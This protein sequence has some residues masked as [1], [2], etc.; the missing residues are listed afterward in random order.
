[1]SPETN[2]EDIDLIPS[3][4]DDVALLVDI[5]SGEKVCA[6]GAMSLPLSRLNEN[7]CLSMKLD[8]KA[9]PNARIELELGSRGQFASR[10]FAYIH[11]V[12]L[13]DCKVIC[14]HKTKA[15]LTKSWPSPSNTFTG[16]VIGRSPTSFTCRMDRGSEICTGFCFGIS[17]VKLSLPRAPHH[18]GYDY[19]LRHF[20]AYARE[21]N[22]S[23]G[24]SDEFLVFRNNMWENAE[25]K[26]DLAIFFKQA[27]EAWNRDCN[28]FGQIINQK[29]TVIAVARLDNEENYRRRVSLT[30]CAHEGIVNNATDITSSHVFEHL[31]GYD[32]PPLLQ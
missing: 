2:E 11:A 16:N 8:L 15:T 31:F 20:R 25:S 13:S 32:E 14:I 27:K 17:G 22:I 7:G 3:S 9:E 1:M 18:Y 12:R 21:N 6:S 4:T 30:T 24:D 5:Y 28:Y 19:T 10:T 29:A 26:A 23:I